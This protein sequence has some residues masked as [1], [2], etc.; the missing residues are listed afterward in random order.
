MK[1]TVPKGVTRAFYRSGAKI[2]KHSPEIMLGVGIASM[3]GAIVTASKNTPKARAVIEESRADLEKIE[4]CTQREDIEYSDETR[5]KDLV[6]VYTR[7]IV[8]VV[9]AYAVPAALTALGIVSILTSHGVMKKRNVALAATC[10][11]LANDLKSYRDNVV[12][13]FGEKVDRQLRFGAEEKEIETVVKD[14]N[15][16]EREEKRSEEVMRTDTAQFS[17]FARCFDEFS[18]YYSKNAEANL[19]FI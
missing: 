18:R 6:I 1:I 5:K 7:T 16:N 9:K 11:A 10:A 13:R 14:E 12:K 2:R 3:L 8:G 15:G 4:T 17:E 19:V